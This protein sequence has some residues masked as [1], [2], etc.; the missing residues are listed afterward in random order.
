MNV[1]NKFTI[2][3]LKKNKTRTVVTIIGIILSVSMFT[4]VTESFIS[5]QNFAIEYVEKTVGSFLFYSENKSKEELEALGKD[6]DVEETAY[7][8]E[9]GYGKYPLAIKEKP[10]IFVSGMSKN[11][12]DVVFLKVIKGRLPQNSSEILMSYS[13]KKEDGSTFEVGESVTLELCDRYLN[14]ERL[15]QEKYYSEEE[16]LQSLKTKTYTVVGIMQRPDREIESYMAPG[17]TAYTCADGTSEM[18]TVYVKA[19]NMKSLIERINDKENPSAWTYGIPTVFNDAYAMYSGYISNVGLSSLIVGFL[20]MLILIIMFGSVALIYNSFSISVSERTKQFGLL[21]SIGATKKQMIKT[22]LF[23]DFCLCIV[24]VPLGL[25]FGCLG[26]SL[27]FKAVD[28]TIAS[29]F[30]TLPDGLS[31]QLKLKPIALVTAAVI[32]VISSLISAYVPAR[33]AVSKSA[34]ESIRQTDEIKIDP[35]KVKTSPLTYK[36][37]GFSGMIASKN[38]KRNKKKYRATVISLFTSVVLFISASSLCSYFKTGISYQ[39]AEYENYDILVF[40]NSDVPVDDS[41]VNAINSVEGIDQ[42]TMSVESRFDFFDTKNISDF[43]RNRLENKKS[44]I[45]S[46]S[47]EI[48]FVD[49]EVFKAL[50]KENKLSQ[51]EFMNMSSPKAVLYDECIYYSIVNDKETRTMYS[52]FNHK[53]I[54]FDLT[55][56][57]NLSYFT[58]NDKSYYFD[59]DS[60]VQ[61][62]EVYLKFMLSADEG[63]ALPTESEALWQKAH[64]KMLSIGAVIDEAPYYISN[65]TTLIYPLS[66]KDIV[67]EGLERENYIRFYIKAKDHKKV[68]ADISSALDGMNTEL[69]YVSDYAQEVENYR[70]IIFIINVFAYG[71]IVLISLIAAANVLNTITTNIYL[72]RRELAML[73]SVGMTNKDFNKMMCFESILYGLKSLLYG[74]PVSTDLVYVFYY[75]VYESGFEIEFYLPVGSFAV[76]I[77]SVFLVVFLSM[78]YSVKKVNKENIVDNLKNENI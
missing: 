10:Y 44:E 37:F 68:T 76:A 8:E 32:S 31:L 74:L 23:E 13:A 67:A 19:K 55:V 36:L 46:Q 42:M 52:S 47:M 61:N 57:N 63:E 11:F 60:K 54:P 50:L 27:A 2:E 65:Q 21:K 12:T 49:D 28:T 72:R 24:A 30:T 40:S 16:T 15:T 53:N 22:V 34:L 58:V 20:V 25:F 69:L 51:S 7:V 26:I 62:G 59:G 41:V 3:S 48:R 1:F 29:L 77:I 9:V 18:Y 38:F 5:A 45:M 56:Y 4:A 17:C 43:V 64:A 71:F 73:K 33:K 70:G 6:E 78:I 75:I 66:A 39:T 35:K 14:D